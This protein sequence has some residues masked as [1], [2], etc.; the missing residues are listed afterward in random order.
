[1]SANFCYRNMQMIENQSQRD[2]L[3]DALADLKHDLG[4][5]LRMP[6]AMLPGDASGDE[7][8][9]ALDTALNRTRTGPGGTRTARSI[10]QD[11]LDEA[12]EGLHGMETFVRLELVV[13]D[14]LGWED[15]ARPDRPGPHREIIEK[16]LGAVS[17]A[18]QQLLE[19]VSGE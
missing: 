1:M 19:E 12:G 10:W 7:V 8:L 4:K 13:A 17:P 5:Y 11:F 6:F 2:D 15:L 16:D 18:I 14:A 9:Q 3:I